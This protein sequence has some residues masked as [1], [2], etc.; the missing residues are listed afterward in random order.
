[1]ILV[2]RYLKGTLDHDLLLN[3]SSPTILTVYSD[4]NWAGCLET[5]R[6]TFGYCVFWVIILFHGLP[7]GK[8][9]FP[10][11]QLKWSTGRLLILLLKRFGFVNFLSSSVD[12]L[13]E[14]L[15]STVTMF[16]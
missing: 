2:A 13:S 14:Q 3:S 12:Q 7:R 8:F 10:G 4:A 16:P 5:Q 9:L 1:V 11:P 15:S 6:S